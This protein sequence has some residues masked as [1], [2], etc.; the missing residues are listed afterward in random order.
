VSTQEHGDLPP[1]RDG[2]IDRGAY[3]RQ[4]RPVSDDQQVAV[5]R[6]DLEAAPQ[7]AVEPGVVADTQAPQPLVRWGSGDREQI[8]GA[9]RAIEAGNRHGRQQQPRRARRQN[10]HVLARPHTARDRGCLPALQ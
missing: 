7:R 8:D 9:A 3:A 1:G 5:A 10:V 2:L 4:A 6:V